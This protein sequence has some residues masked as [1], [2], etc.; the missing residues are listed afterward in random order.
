VIEQIRKST[1]DYIAK[2]SPEMM[3]IGENSQAMILALKQELGS[4]SDLGILKDAMGRSSIEGRKV[5]NEMF[6]QNVS[7]VSQSHN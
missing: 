4:R 1:T 3:T 7:D 6:P 2:V 5:L